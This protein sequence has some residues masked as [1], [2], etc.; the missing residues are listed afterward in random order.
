MDLTIKFRVQI[1]LKCAKFNRWIIDFILEKKQKN[2]LVYI[3]IIDYQ[4]NKN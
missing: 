2:R 1:Y 3:I 4:E